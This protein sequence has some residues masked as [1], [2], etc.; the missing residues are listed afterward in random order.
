VY[1]GTQPAIGQNRKLDSIAASFNGVLTTFSLT[2]NTQ[3][4]VPSNVYQLFISLGGVLQDPGVDFTANGNQITFTTAPVSGLSFFGVFQGDS[5]TGTPTIADAS[6]TTLKLATGLTITNTAGTAGAPSVTFAGDTNT[7]IYS[8]GADQVAI[9]TGGTGRLFIDSSGRLL[10][11]TSTARSN[12]FGTTL[13]SLT[14]TEGTGGST[15][16]GSLS[17]INNDVSNNPPYVLLGRSGAATLGSNAVVVSGSRLGTL[18]FHGADGTSFIEAAT[19]AGEVDGTPGSTDMPGRLVFSTTS[20]GAASPTERL[21][22]DSSGRVGVGTSAPEETVDVNGAIT[23][24]GSLNTGKTSAGALDRSGNELRIRAYGATAGTGQLVFRTGGGGGSVDSEA[25]RIDSSQRV[26]IGTSV[27]TDSSGYGTTLDIRGSGTGNGAVIYLRNSDASV[28]GQIAAYGDGRMD[29]GT[30]T[31]H[32]LK[33]FTNNSEK[34]RITSAGL[35]GIGTTSP[36][37]ALDVNGSIQ[38]PSNNALYISG[39]NNYLYADSSATELASSTQIVFV[40]N[41][42]QRAKIDSSGRLLVGTSSQIDS[43]APSIQTANSTGAGI[44][45]GRSDTTITS[46]E[47]LGALSFHG[48]HGSTWGESGG[49]FCFADADHGSGDYPSRLVFS[50]TADGAASPTER[51]RID[52]DGHARFSQQN[53]SAD[54]SSTNYGFVI[55]AGSQPFI[56]HGITGTSLSTMYVFINGNGVVG[57]IKTTGSSTQYNTSSDYRLKENVEPITGA[58]DRILQLKPSR[59]NF[60]ADATKTV[61]GFIAHEVQEVVPEAI[62]GDKDAVDDNGDPDYQGIDQSKLV[63]LLTA[64]L[65]EAIAK[66]ETLEA[67]LT[68]AGIE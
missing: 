45:L 65:Q 27:P 22:I 60:I 35:V 59:F 51:M 24:R 55:Q 15:A 9:T 52:R 25:M 28:T 44:F 31:A 8:P 2:V 46:G 61:D 53:F 30:T 34:V 43:R 41:G 38:L 66:I 33:F 39:S 20:D 50:T 19:V 10:V 32:P 6:I 40:A 54:V 18:T 56:N 68:A 5:I 21:R 7:G 36:A 58:S 63:P 62:S 12:F 11:G 13:S 42:S 1:L 14:Q 64:A 26:G 47:F 16:R 3:S 37:R 57:T 17:V 23:W 29:L 4:V 48:Y 67:R 49:I